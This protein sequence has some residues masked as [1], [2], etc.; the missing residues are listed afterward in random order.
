MELGLNEYDFSHFLIDFAVFKVKLGQVRRKV[1][2]FVSLNGTALS[3]LAFIR[4][5]YYV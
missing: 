5:S 3:L 4:F 1:Y 2:F